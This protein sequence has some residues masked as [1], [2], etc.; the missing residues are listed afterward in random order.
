MDKFDIIEKAY[1]NIKFLFHT[2]SLSIITI[3][4]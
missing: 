4:T 2:E 3:S 1:F